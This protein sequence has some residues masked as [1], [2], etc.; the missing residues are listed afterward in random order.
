[1]KG[2]SD[3]KASSFVPFSLIKT[4]PQM[5]TPSIHT[6]NREGEAGCAIPGQSNK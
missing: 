2:F 6:H 5:L 4:E 3:F 1:V